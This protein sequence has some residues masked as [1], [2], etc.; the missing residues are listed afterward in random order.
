L[1]TPQLTRSPSPRRQTDGSGWIKVTSPAG[2][3]GLIPASYA[4]LLALASPDR[5]GS[6][7]S[8]SSASAS[9]SDSLRGGEPTTTNGGGGGGGGGGS[10]KRGPAVAPKRGARKVAHV[11]ALYAYAARGDGEHSMQEGERLVLVT[12]DAGDGWAEVERGGRVGCVPAS[13]VR[14]C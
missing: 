9:V 14:D 12:R 13:Y 6:V 3:T 5:P 2:S 11:Q 8:A 4:E 1:L 7:Y 10:K